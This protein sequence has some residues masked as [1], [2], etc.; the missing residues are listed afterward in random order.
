MG[1]FIR[2]VTA[3]MC[4]LILI[5]GFGAH[6]AAV[7][8]CETE[9]LQEETPAYAQ[10]EDLTLELHLVKET[11]PISIPNPE[12][13]V[14]EEDVL[15]KDFPY[16][17]TYDALDRLKKENHK[18]KKVKGLMVQAKNGQKYRLSKGKSFHL[19][20]SDAKSPA[21]NYTA[22]IPAGKKL[23]QKN[24][25]P[26]TYVLVEDLRVDVKPPGNFQVALKLDRLT[27]V[28]RI[29]DPGT[30]GMGTILTVEPRK[31]P[32]GGYVKLTVRKEDFE[33]S[34]ARFSVCLRLHGKDE[35]RAFTASDDVELQKTLAGEAVLRARIPEKIE[36]LD[37]LYLDQ[38]VD[39]LV[40]ARI[41]GDRVER[42]EVMTREF[43][44]SSRG[45]A[46]ATW[47]LAFVLPWFFA[48][49][50]RFK[51]DAVAAARTS[52]TTVEKDLE[53][54]KKVRDPDPAK[55]AEL[56]TKIEKQKKVL[57]KAQALSEHR[58][59]AYLA[60]LNP[61]WMVSGK[62]GGASL[63]LAQILLW[64]ILVFSASFYVW[65]VSGKLLDLTNDVLILLGIAGGASMIAKITAA[66]K[67]EKGQAIVGADGKE[68]KWLDLIRTEGR[69]D[70]YKFQMALFTVL[71]A[72]FVTGKIYVNLEFPV[73]PSGLLTL[74]GISNGVY[75][76][77]K[78]SSKTAFEELAEIDSERQ[79]VNK[80]LQDQPF[81]GD[82]C[83][84]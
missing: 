7:D 83:M 71:A 19:V 79:A 35:P 81:Q 43:S 57:K 28:L 24:S 77:A 80:N 10:P 29:P 47:I 20:L 55:T 49:F 73:L 40:V 59:K 16:T 52:L 13:F 48:A 8:S 51:R 44:V 2:K 78:A 14:N 58:V 18:V 22:I 54:V 53:D 62:I 74:I 27:K 26:G 84:I 50:V 1:D 15:K 33:F 34:K 41:S 75:L 69:P 36:G 11:D 67:D 82:T 66:A 56:T 46:V 38:P 6:A 42:A 68:P 60:E 45:L 21:A 70:L 12:E 5:C 65:V 31:A 3:A 76:T 63:S 4:G 23:K 32:P 25:E 72:A 9:V 39:L 61:I 37:G 30:S 64:S 17:L